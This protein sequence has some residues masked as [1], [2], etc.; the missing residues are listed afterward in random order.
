MTQAASACQPEFASSHK[1]T[2]PMRHEAAKMWS[3]ESS[4][5]RIRAPIRRRL[6]DDAN[7][8]SHFERLVVGLA[9]AH[10]ERP[11]RERL[12]SIT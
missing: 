7:F 9:F 4:K 11:E 2:A 5:R 1:E 12:S 3:L 10:F 6:Y 8:S